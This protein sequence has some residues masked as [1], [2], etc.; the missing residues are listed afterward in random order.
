MRKSLTGSWG[1]DLAQS[2]YNIGD[3]ISNTFGLTLD[4]D[5]VV[6]NMSVV[7]FVSNTNSYQIIQAEE[8]YIME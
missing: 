2:D 4:E 8:K 1:V 3:V 5:W 6:E 7:A